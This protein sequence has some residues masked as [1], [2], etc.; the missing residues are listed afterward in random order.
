LCFHFALSRRQ[1]FS[2]KNQGM[3]RL[4]LLFVLLAA[5]LSQLFFILPVSASA[6]ESL[7]LI[8]ENHENFQFQ[9]TN[10]SLQF[11]F[12]N[13]IHRFMSFLRLARLATQRKR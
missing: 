13:K 5:G 6:G 12:S 4:G 10:F 11:I 2:E 7:A 3:A 1:I 8:S 9:T